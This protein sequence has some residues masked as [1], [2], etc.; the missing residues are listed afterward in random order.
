MPIRILAVAPSNSAADLFVERLTNLNKADLLRLNAISRSVA[1]TPLVVK[2]YSS[3]V[4]DTFTLIPRESVLKFRVV[5]STAMSAACLAGV[6]CRPGDFTHIV[7][8][9]AGHATEP[10][11]VAALGGLIDPKLT[12][13]IL[14]GDPQQLGP[15]VRSTDAIKGG[16]GVSLLERL[17]QPYVGPGSDG[18]GGGPS[19]ASDADGRYMTK[20]LHNYRS[21]PA[22]LHTPNELF[23]SSELIAAA[24]LLER[25]SLCK[26]PSFPAADFP[27]LF[28]HIVGKEQRVESSPSWQ[29][30][31]E[32]VL[33]CEYVE[34]L[35]A[36]KQAGL[37]PKD[38]GVISPYHRQV[39][40]IRSSLHTRFERMGRADEWRDLK[41]ET[42]DTRGRSAVDPPS[43]CA[44]TQVH[45]CPLF[46]PSWSSFLPFRSFRW[47][48]ARSSRARSV[49]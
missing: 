17:M 36:F 4:G 45:S 28:H 13:V 41:V 14:G 46:L 21:H 38:I 25:R 27:L 37:T 43:A 8:D 30:L 22:I 47:V 49:A 35:L 24:D 33:V 23:Y 40:Q 42:P 15:V 48:R 12:R 29:N 9:E 16:L 7:C 19:P 6:G 5:V 1:E 10:E 11:L 26:W 39:T 32:C 44:L 3:V 18:Q 34:Q 31:D 20:L 2:G